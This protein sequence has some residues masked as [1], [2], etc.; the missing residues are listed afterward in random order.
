MPEDIEK[1]IARLERLVDTIPGLIRR[2]AALEA[3]TVGQQVEPPHAKK[4]EVEIYEIEGAP[5]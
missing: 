2:I 1:R 3:A 5:V 4:I